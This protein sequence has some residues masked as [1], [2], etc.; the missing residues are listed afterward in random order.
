MDAYTIQDL[1]VGQ[2]ASFT[3]T[4][5]ESDVYLYA[6]ITG[7]FNPLHIDAQHAEKTMFKKRIVHGALLTGFISNVLGMKLP[8]PG[9]LYASQEL[10]F[11][12][13]VYIGDTITAF[14]EVLEI[15][16]QKNRV[17]FRTGCI[18]Q[19]DEL[20]AEGTS[21]LLPTKSNQPTNQ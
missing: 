9:A 13:P 17:L 3:K 16:E 15:K 21:I 10:A 14:V 1:L 2:R 4:I 7:D 5:S 18:N 6:G 8:G 20:V 12:K 11:K 19:N